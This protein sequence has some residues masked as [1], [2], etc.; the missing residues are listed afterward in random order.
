MNYIYNIDRYWCDMMRDGW[1]MIVLVFI[2][3]VVY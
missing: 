2:E 1:M 3:R